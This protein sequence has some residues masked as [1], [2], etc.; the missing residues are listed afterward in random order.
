MRESGL[1]RTKR[2]SDL[3]GRVVES[4]L[5]EE[6]P[7]EDQQAAFLWECQRMFLTSEQGAH[8]FQRGDQSG[9]KLKRV[10]QPSIEEVLQRA[11]PPGQESVG[12][13]LWNFRDKRKRTRVI[14]SASR[15]ICLNKPSR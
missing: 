13:R 9:F 5:S 1:D 6:V 14:A 8:S 11:L 15:A 3:F 12:G 7:S 10:G 2:G 4:E